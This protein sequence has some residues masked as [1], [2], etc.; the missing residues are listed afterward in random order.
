MEPPWPKT[1]R[2]VWRE[3]RSL[4]QTPRPVFGLARFG[5]KRKRQFRSLVHFQWSSPLLIFGVQIL[6]FFLFCFSAFQKT[7]VLHS[8][9][10]SLSLGHF[11]LFEKKSK[12]KRR[13]TAKIITVITVPNC[14]ILNIRSI[15]FL[16][17]HVSYYRLRPG[18]ISGTKK[19]FPL[20]Y[21]DIV[22]FVIKIADC[23]PFQSISAGSKSHKP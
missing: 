16:S 19:T 8:N 15:F 23:R 14:L 20:F 18:T 1:V 9:A 6:S 10:S 21:C 17:N 11:C 13:S 12:S 3:R 5:E 22:E 4:R 2:G 7:K